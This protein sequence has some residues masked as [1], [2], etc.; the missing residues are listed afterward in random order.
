MTRILGY[1]LPGLL[2]YLLFLALQ[3]PASVVTEQFAKQLPGFSVQTVEGA[4]ID[5]SAQGVAWRSVRL[6]RLQWAW[7]PLALFTGWLEFHLNVDDP[8]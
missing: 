1:G 5:G 6:D 4:A 8:E 3:A 7:R 2:A